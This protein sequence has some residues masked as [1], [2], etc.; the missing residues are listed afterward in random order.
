[1]IHI[2]AHV[3]LFDSHAESILPSTNINFRG[4]IDVDASGKLHAL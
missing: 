1:M 2:Y 3:L 4:E